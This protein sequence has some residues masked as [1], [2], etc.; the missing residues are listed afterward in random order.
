MD[1]NPR[2]SLS[3]SLSNEGEGWEDRSRNGDGG[4]GNRTL[5]LRPENK[6]ISINL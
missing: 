4:C 5:V 6:A 1:L 2:V 3:I